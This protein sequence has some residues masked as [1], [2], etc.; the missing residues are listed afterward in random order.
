MIPRKS[1]D[2]LY[3][4]VMSYE[5]IDEV[6]RVSVRIGVIGEGEEKFCVELIRKG[7]DVSV[8]DKRGFVDSYEWKERLRTGRCPMLELAGSLNP[9]L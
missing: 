2:R 1:S 7:S 9:G 4:L 3:I 8:L 6:Q 5:E